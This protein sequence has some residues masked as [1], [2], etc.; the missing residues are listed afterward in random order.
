MC[1]TAY[2]PLDNVFF[3]KDF[4]TVKNA[5]IGEPIITEK[6]RSSFSKYEAL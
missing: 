3:S 1:N 4:G 2:F 5:S 6:R